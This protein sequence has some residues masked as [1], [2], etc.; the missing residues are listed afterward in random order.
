MIQTPR[1]AENAQQKAAETAAYLYLNFLWDT[2]AMESGN[3]KKKPPTQ[4]TKCKF[5]T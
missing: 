3:L 5:I 4:N 1:N 2:S